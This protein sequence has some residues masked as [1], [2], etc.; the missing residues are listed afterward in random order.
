MKDFAGNELEIGDRVL[1]C[2]PYY[3]HMVWAEVERFGEQMI[4]C[5]YRPNDDPTRYRK[6]VPRYPNQ[7]VLP[8]TPRTEHAIALE[9]QSSGDWSWRDFYKDPSC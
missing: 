7:V 1:I 6:T 5:S 9:T 3:K 8:L 4:V 2:L